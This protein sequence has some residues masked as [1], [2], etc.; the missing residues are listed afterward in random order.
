MGHA[1]G[2]W[3]GAKGIWP[4]DL[5]ET[6]RRAAELMISFISKSPRGKAVPKRTQRQDLRSGALDANTYNTYIDVY[7]YA[8]VCAYVYV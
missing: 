7:V 8:C 3:F 1:S 2:R 4:V 5:S 6:H